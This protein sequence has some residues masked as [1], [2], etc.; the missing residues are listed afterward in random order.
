MLWKSKRSHFIKTIA[1]IYG[2]SAITD[3]DTRDG[4]DLLSIKKNRNDLAHGFLSF[5]EVG[6]IHLRK[7]WLK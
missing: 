7:I 6:K 2:F 4:I 5:K 1:K 3:H